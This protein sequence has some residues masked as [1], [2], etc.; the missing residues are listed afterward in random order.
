VLK[1]EYKRADPYL[2]EAVGILR[3]KPNLE[4]WIGQAQMCRA[5]ALI[6]LGRAAEAEPM[7]K[8]A[9]PKYQKDQRVFSW[10]KQR[11][12]EAVAA[13]YDQAGQTAKAAE[14]R[15]KLAA[16]SEPGPE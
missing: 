9:W 7:L 15:A 6:G 3:E 11:T 2:R 13:A 16:K 8:D 5:T 12:I 14:W 10:Q 1:E 4:D